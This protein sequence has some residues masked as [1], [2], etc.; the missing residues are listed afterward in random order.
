MSRR[1]EVE[2]TS[3]RDDGSWTWRA[4]GAKQPKGVLDGSLLPA[5]SRVGD[6]FRADVETGLDGIEV[7]AVMAPKGARPEPERL[8]ILGTGTEQPLVTTTLAGRR[9]GDRGERRDRGDRPNKGPRR[10]GGRDRESRP[11]G[12]RAGA[13]RTRDGGGRVA[14][15]RP[16]EGDGSRQDKSNAAAGGHGRERVRRPR[17]PVD[18]RP[19]PKRLRAKSANR[20]EALDSLPA[21]QQPLAEQVLKGGIPAVRQAVAKQNEQ[22][23]AEGRPEVKAEPLVVLAEGLLPKLRAAEWRDRAEAAIADIDELDLRDLR[24]VVVAADGAARDDESRAMAT[25]LREGL[26]RRVEREQANWL[27]ELAATLSD[28]RVIRA[29]RLSS[30]PPKAGSPL[31]PDLAQRLT[32]S[33]SAALTADAGTD[34]WTAMLDA[35]QFA[36]VHQKVE[37]VS[38]PEKPS[39]ELLA[40]VRKATSRLPQIAAKFGIETTGPAARPPRGRKTKPTNKSSANAPV[41]PPPPAPPATGDQR[42]IVPSPDP[43]EPP[44]PDVVPDPQPA[45]VPE[46]SPQPQPEPHPQPQLQPEPMP[47]PSAAAGDGGRDRDGVGDT[48][49]S[50]EP[51]G[52]T[53]E[54]DLPPG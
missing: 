50:P 48:N 1:I 23:R 34:R 22:A 25:E 13:T 33:A 26:T 27:T 39:D 28:G 47:A 20:K 6:E 38:Y 42:P 51:A 52:P 40:A 46:P 8:E 17:P 10:E 19:K 43:T 41:P 3:S 49:H 36:P 30:R 54:D 45:P 44:R 12:P 4:A 53:A 32:E 2:L 37:P 29:L 31:P 11:G 21:E 35:L 24:S 9:G 16:S 7:V 15:E 14:R 18:T 5:G